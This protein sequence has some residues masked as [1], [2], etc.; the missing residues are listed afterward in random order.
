MSFIFT[1]PGGQEPTQVVPLNARELLHLVQVDW[2]VMHSAQG[3][4]QNAQTPL[5][6]TLPGGH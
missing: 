4:L 5:I 3:T 1:V 6:S 2:L